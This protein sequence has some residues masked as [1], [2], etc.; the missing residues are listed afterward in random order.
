MATHANQAGAG[1]FTPSD[2]PLVAIAQDHLEQLERQLPAFE[3][4]LPLSALQQGLLFHTRYDQ[5]EATA[6]IIQQR[7]NLAGPLDVSALR[8]AATALL[9]RHANLRAAFLHDGLQ[10]P[11]QVIAREVTLPWQEIDLSSLR[12]E[13]RDAELARWLQADAI[14][15]FDP[16]QA[17]LLRFAL[18]RLAPGL[19]RLVFTSHHILLDGWSMPILVDELFSL[20]RSRGSAAGLP[21]SAPYRNYLAWLAQQDRSAA[22]K[23]W[24]DAF[25]GL[26]E[27]TALTPTSTMPSS[28]GRQEITVHHLPAELSGA[29][30]K[31]ARTHGLTLNTL[32]QGAWGMLLG[33]LTGRNDAVFGI[34]VSGRPPELPG[35]ERMVGLFI[36]T[37]PLRLRFKMSEPAIE[38]LKRLQNEQSSLMAH[39]HLG[40]PDI[41]RLAGLPTLFDTLLVF[42]SFPAD[43]SARNPKMDELQISRAGSHGGDTTH[44]P[45]SIVAIPGERLQLR[46]GYRPDLLARA[47]VEQLVARLQ[48]VLEAI[49]ANPFQPVGQI[50]ITAPEER[51]QI[52]SGWSSTAHAVHSAAEA[53]LPTLFEQHAARTPEATALVF[54]DASLT[55]AELN[56]R[57]NQLAH[58]LIAQGVGPEGFVAIALPRSLELIVS[59]LAVLKTGAAYLPLDVDYPKDRLAFMLEDAAPA[60]TITDTATSTLLPSDA[61]ALVMLDHPATSDVLARASRADPTDAQRRHPLRPTHPAYVIYTSGSTGRPK[62][63]IIPQQNVVRLLDTTEDWFRFGQDDV[64][65]MFHSHAFDFS[66]WEIWGALLRG[67]RLVVV[68]STV[69]RSPAE[70]LRLLVRERVTILNQTPSAF[71]QLVQAD[72]EHP[73]LRAGLTLRRIIFGGEALELARLKDWYAKHDDDAPLLV[74]MYGITETT[75]H[76]SYAALNSALASG[77]SNSLIGRGIPDLQV[78]VLDAALQPVPAGVPGE[79]YIAGAGLARGYLHRPGLSAERFIANPFGS[80]GSRM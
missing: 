15:P 12:P 9:Q 4:I 69:S 32:L 55:Y 39:Q 36:N 22:Q 66:V 6:Y 79:L 2:F 19:A 1:G 60:C 80:P 52:L 43:A 17:P 40:L 64:W 14:L 35:V 44:Y 75:V 47:T 71:H 53:T 42:E 27:S 5:D 63:V 77:E 41:Q 7:F 70:F 58:H 57:A 26:A 31:Q 10:E 18:I 25:A 30:E 33:R 59:L 34:T 48:R 78:Y 49:A 76:V 61:H 51:A 21:P 3:D 28:S 13:A 29:L 50:E 73:E 16:A 62:G 23:A 72:A 74:N 11:V 65:T 38:T 24:Q 8:A 54:E 67:G 46:A 68:P 56:A 45:L 37:L 20:Y